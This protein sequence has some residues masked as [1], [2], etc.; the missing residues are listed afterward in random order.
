M[1]CS[2]V[3][4]HNTLTLLLC[5]TIFQWLPIVYRTNPKLLMQPKIPVPSWARSH[6]FFSTILVIFPHEH[7]LLPFL[8]TEYLA[9]LLFSFPSFLVPVLNDEFLFTAQGSTQQ[10]PPDHSEC[11]RLLFEAP[12][13]HAHIQIWYHTENSYATHSAKCFACVCFVCVILLMARTPSAVYCD[14]PL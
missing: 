2:A 9:S 12:C 7:W 6:L 11:S 4:W 3:F 14:Y 5:L 1:F 10:T 8:F 13:L